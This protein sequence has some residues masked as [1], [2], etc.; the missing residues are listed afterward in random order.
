MSNATS[1]LLKTAKKVLAPTY[2]Q[3]DI[4]FVKGK[5]SF[6]EDDKGEQYLDFT[7]GIAVS[8]LGHCP[9]V[10]T[11]ALK[12]ASERLIHTSNLF[13]TPDSILLAQALTEASFADKV[14]FCNSGAEAVE[15]AIKFA[16]L[17][18]GEN[19]KEIISFSGSFHGRTLGALTATDRPDFKNPFTPLPEKFKI[20]PFASEEALSS[21]TE[22]TAGVMVEPIQGE[23]GIITAPTPWLKA[24]R[25]RC[26]ETGTLLI[27]DEV[28][29]GLG[30][31]GKLWDYEHSGVLPDIMTLAKP[32]AGGL[33]IGAILMTEKVAEKLSAGCHGTTFGGNP[34]ICHVALRVLASIQAPSFLEDVTRKGNLLKE[35]IQEA[36][37]DG[38]EEVRGKGLLIGLKLS[39]PSADLVLAA[40]KNHLLIPQ[41][42]A[43]VVRLLPPLTVS[44]EEIELGVERLKQ[45]IADLKNEKGKK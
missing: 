22:E 27:F 40:R 45:S 15:G 31:T 25:K 13:Y 12:E 39:F 28:Q 30:R 14:F 16:R 36:Q 10:I 17:H 5:G 4:L 41:A 23:G 8:A 1:P 9:Q 34:L 24:L 37:L 26:D 42:G 3:P 21:I 11:D 38:V 19:R 32:L 2:R 20:L 44:E 6:L 7:S 43:E 18:G 29:C 33:P 35:K